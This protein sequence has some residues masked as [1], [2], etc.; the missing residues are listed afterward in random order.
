MS[1]LASV[2]LN[3]IRS[4]WHCESRLLQFVVE[5]SHAVGFVVTQHRVA[6]AGELVGKRADGFVV[7]AALLEL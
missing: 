1:L 3:S 7:V 2:E 6:D 5:A 4:G